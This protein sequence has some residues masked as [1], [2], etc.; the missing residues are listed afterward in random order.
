M[1]WDET[2]KSDYKRWEEFHFFF[3]GLA[4]GWEEQ[5]LTVGKRVKLTQLRVHF[6][7]TFVSTED[8]I[9][10]VSSIRGSAY[11]IKILSQT[12]SD[13][14]D[15]VVIYTSD[16]IEVLSDD[17]IVFAASMKSNIHLYGLEVLGWAV[18]NNS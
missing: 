15:L 18:A 11:N 1:T 16:A 7:S 17:H 9:V 6:D 10:Y 5:S 14:Q 2:Q 12:L 8:L 4:N 13:V 3:Q